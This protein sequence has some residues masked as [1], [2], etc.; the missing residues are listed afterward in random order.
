MNEENVEEN[1]EESEI[2]DDSTVETD[3]DPRDTQIANLNQA[4]HREREQIRRLKSSAPSPQVQPNEDGSIDPNAFAQSVN[5]QTQ[6]TVQSILQDDREWNKA[7]KKYP[8]LEDEDIADAIKGMKTSA[9]VNRGEIISYE[10]AA[11]KVLGKLKKNA[12]KNVT[13]AKEQGRTEAQVSERIQERA[14]ID[15]PSG[16]K[17]TTDKKAEVMKVLYNPDST[18]DERSAAR[19]QLLNF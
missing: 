8:D 12:D 3:P 9:L 1:Y 7:S 15:A 14:V 11:E 16:G 5:Q 10:E 4:L 17:E 6:Q 18:D 2:L 19:E 13:D